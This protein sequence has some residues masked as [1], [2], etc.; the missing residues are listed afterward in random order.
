[1]SLDRSHPRHA[2]SFRQ[3]AFAGIAYQ[4]VVSLYALL[5]PAI[6]SRRFDEHVLGLWLTAY[7]LFGLVQASNLGIP[8][9]L[10]SQVDGRDSANP[11]ANA[12]LVRSAVVLTSGY[13]AT[14]LLLALLSPILPWDRLFTLPG[15]VGAP[16]G[17]LAMLFLF[18]AFT[19]LAGLTQPLYLALHRGHQSY[20]VTSLVHLAWIPCVVIGAW[21][22]APFTIMAALF[23]TPPLLSGLLLWAIGLRRGYVAVATTGAPGALGDLWRAGAPFLA[24]DLASSLVLRTPEAFVSHAHGLA[25]AARFSVIQRFPFLLSA[26]LTVVLQPLW[27]SLAI[28]AR[29]ADRDGARALVGKAIRS[30]LILWA[31]FAVMVLSVGEP[32]VRKWL[33]TQLGQSPANLPLAVGLGLVQSLHYCVALVLVGLGAGRANLRVNLLMLAGYLPAV[34]VLSAKLGAPGAFVALILVFA[35]LGIPI[36]FVQVRRRLRRMDTDRADAR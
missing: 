8:G 25:E 35:L 2:K 31:I 1:V 21:L 32:L 36:G 19:L 26:V 5:L 18:T 10:L 24:M 7:S 15:A 11:T 4:G 27:P 28:A 22:R 23:L 29:T 34:F 3:T 12:T 30:A 20:V 14:P 17:F 6:V 16:G 33:G 9:V 13:A